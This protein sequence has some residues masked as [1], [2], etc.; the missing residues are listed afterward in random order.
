MN[1]KKALLALLACIVLFAGAVVFALTFSGQGNG[2]NGN[3]HPIVLSEIL[4]GNRTYIS[5]NGKYLDFVEVRNNSDSPVDISG[6]MIS[7]RPDYIGYTFPQGT[8]LQAHSAIV[9]WCDKESDSDR[10]GKFGISRKGDD[11]ILLYNKANVLIDQYTVPVVEENVP[12]VR[13]EDGTWATAVYATPGFENTD[14]GFEKWLKSVDAESVSVVISEVMSGSGFAIIDGEGNQSDWVELLNTGNKAVVLDGAFLSDDPQN[15]TKWQI[16]SMTIKPGDRALIRCAGAAAGA[17]E[18]SFALARDGG[19]VILTGI[20]G[21][22]ISMVEYPKLGKECSWALQDDGS[23]LETAKTTPGYE[24]TEAGYDA[25]L[26]AV[27]F[28]TPEIRI[29][30]VMSANRSTV[31]SSAGELCDWIELYNAGN[32]DVLLNGLYLSNDASDRMKWMLPDITLCAG[33]RTVIKCS[34]SDAPVSEADFSLPREGCTVILSGAAGNVIDQVDVPRLG[35]DRTW[36]LQSN[37]IFAEC[38]YPSPGYDN[39]KEGYSAFRATQVVTGPLIISEVMPSNCT[40]LMQSDGEYYDWVELKN[41]SEAPVDLGRYSL[42]DDPGKL[43]KFPLPDTTLQ[44]G[45]T[46]LIMCSGNTQLTNKKYTHA[47]FTLSREESWVYLSL[48]AEGGCRDYVRIYDVPYQHSVGRVDGENGTYYFTKPT[49]GAVNGSGVAF[50]SATPVVVTPDGVYNNVDS[51]SV[52][53]NGDGPL[54]YTLDGST[55]TKNSKQYTAPLVLKST[56]A[57][58]VACIEEGK[59]TSDVVTAVYIINENHTLPVVS[60]VAQPSTLFGSS[61]IY[62]NYSWDKEVRCNLK[63]FETDGNS[64]T[65]DCGVKM[66]GH[67]GL[68]APKKSF[69]VNFRGRYGQ[70]ILTYPVYGEDGPDVYDSLIIRAGQDYPTAIFRDELFTSLARDISDE[71]L[72]QRDKFSILYINGEYYGIYCIKEA[73]TEL[74]Y[75]Q[76]MGGS[77]ENVEIVQ[78]PVDDDH[79]IYALTQFCRNNDMTKD[80]NYE[81]VASKVDIDNLIDYMIIQGYCTNGDVQQNLRYIR[82]KDTGYKWQLAFYDLDWSFYYHNAF[83]H[84]LSPYQSWQHLSLTRGVMKNAQFREKF[85]ARCSELMATTLSNENV[86]A[87]IDYYEELLDPEVPRERARWKN[88]YQGW[89]NNVQKLRDFI[90]VGDEGYDQMGVMIN[91]LIDYIGLTDAE[92]EKYFSRWR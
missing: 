54:Y 26:E 50:I 15:R 88:N 60:I 24:N 20:H 14:A 9:C 74:M 91:K 76:N 66:H 16:P 68:Q 63:L 48:L 1:R 58:R 92:I 2:N 34:G 81:Y 18:A 47:P 84:V 12:V 79:E 49:P 80:E 10:Y 78:A 13:M 65:I 22:T 17:D 90:L 19:S 53:L 72:A 57:V 70:D 11:T 61:G 45:G 64:F 27:G 31:V 40:Y 25:W 21:N 71:M 3:S 35:E 30:E 82:S 86:I 29:S 44:P 39:T 43:D 37:G 4:A 41:I 46:I 89:K 51:V 8:I 85:L 56:T 6:Y 75:A 77:P 7:D 67:T 36:A 55:P 28:A 69:K 87:R 38:D 59:L 23:Y 52:E 5:P 62:T 42:S 83:K 33:E 32:E 73:W